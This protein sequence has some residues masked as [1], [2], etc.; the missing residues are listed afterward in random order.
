MRSRYLLSLPVIFLFI[1]QSALLYA[2]YYALAYSSPLVPWL[3]TLVCTA[4]IAGGFLFAM[5]RLADR[6]VQERFA[7]YVAISA[8][9]TAVVLRT[10]ISVVIGG[11]LP[12]S[13]EVVQGFLVRG[14]IGQVLTLPILIGCG[15]LV[16]LLKRRNNLIS[17]LASEQEALRQ[18]ADA[19]ESELIEAQADVRNQT[20]ALLDPVMREV[21]EVLDE[22]RIRVDAD[23]VAER[24]MIA[25]R[26]FVRPIAHGVVSTSP[27]KVKDIPVVVLKR[28]DVRH[29]RMDVP[30]TL[31]PGWFALVAALI[32]ITPLYFSRLSLET[33]LLKLSGGVVL[34]GLLVLTKVAWPRKL[35]VRPVLSGSI[36]LGLV[37]LILLVLQTYVESAISGD[38]FGNRGEF[39]GFMTKILIF[40]GFTIIGILNQ[41]SQE[42]ERDLVEVN[43]RLQELVATMRRQI[44]LS[45]RAVALAVHGPLQSILV[46]AAMRL[47]ATDGA[48]VS[49]EI[50]RRRLDE[51]LANVGKAGGREVRL[52]DTIN[53]LRDLW[54]GLVDIRYEIDS[55]ATLLMESDAGLQTCV[56]EVCREAISNS[57]RH[58]GAKQ[59][60]VTVMT[61]DQGVRIR[62]EDDG[63]LGGGL[64]QA[65]PSQSGLGLRMFDETCLRWELDFAAAGATRF[66]AVVV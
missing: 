25:V 55:H 57:I 29:D 14:L 24:L 64:G 62:V 52:V 7:A 45:R 10:L 15:L 33:L 63:V 1:V 53:E 18:T 32:F 22:H 6:F 38:P 41:H 17:Q 16:G 26:D 54:E 28:L 9:A 31:Q 12:S 61:E 20:L 13:E 40:V 42:A 4:A 35:R 46:S 11:F 3:T 43:E 58:G 65:A 66:E 60:D 5:G 50:V 56:S 19:M 34:Y 27:V 51:A 2:A 37:F 39:T 44:W 59:V 21:R 47:T 23:A 30:R 36:A 48:E 8:L 49:V